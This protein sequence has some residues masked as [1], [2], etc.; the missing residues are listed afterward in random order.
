MSE[1]ICRGR[2]LHRSVE[3]SRWCVTKVDLADF[4]RLVGSAIM[5]GSIQP[6]ELDP[7]DPCDAQ[8]GPNIYTVNEQFIKP[9][10]RNAG[11]MSWALMLHPRGL[12]CD[13]YITH[14]WV[15]GVFEFINKA[16]HSW[17]PSAR[18]AYCCMLAN[19]Q[20]LDISDLIRFPQE[21]PFAL[22]LVSARYLLVIPNQRVCV[23][24][25]LWCA[26]EA[27]LAYD[28]NMD[29]VVASAPCFDQILKAVGT[30]LLIEFSG[31]AAGLLRHLGPNG[32]MTDAESYVYWCAL[33]GPFLMSV[34]LDS[35]SWR[36]LCH[37]VG[38]FLIAY[39]DVVADMETLGNAVFQTPVWAARIGIFCG[40]GYYIAAEADRVRRNRSGIEREQLTNGYTG[41]ILDAQCSDLR[42]KAAI[43]LQIGAKTGEVDKAIKVV[44]DAGIWTADLRRASDAGVDVTDAG[45][46]EFA[47]LSASSTFAV[48]VASFVILVPDTCC[49]F[50]A[51]AILVLQTC[52]LLLLACQ[53]RGSRAFGFKV[54]GKLSIPWILMA[55]LGHIYALL[56]SG[57]DVRSTTVH[58]WQGWWCLSF[59]V[60]GI[61]LTLAGVGRVSQLPV[62]GR[63]LAQAIMARGIGC[64]CRACCCSLR[65]GSDPRDSCLG[66]QS[67][68][69]ESEV[70]SSS[71]EALASSSSEGLSPAESVSRLPD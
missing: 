18:N 16:L 14:A 29:I 58:R 39:C 17:P 71:D 67:S 60:L 38:A 64:A 11:M 5:E 37:L 24:M 62:F 4:G 63:V 19:P 15:E 27:F 55:L 34:L 61:S 46:V 36:R 56:D 1:G 54:L 28:N 20:N 31:A 32:H 7:F 66:D 40:S 43:S 13:L 52:Q 33:V 69:G 9:V 23:Y 59:H 3:K 22:A 30:V 21:S 70:M 44:V 57:L 10:T 65:T 26:Y 8:I 35:S 42:D 51:I 25:R 12:Q 6:T 49:L 50:V 53:Q 68:N 41:S 45:H 2:E 47:A 48:V